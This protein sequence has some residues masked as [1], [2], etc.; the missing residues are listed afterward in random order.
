MGLVRFG[1]G[2]R[3]NDDNTAMYHKITKTTI[4]QSNDFSHSIGL[5]I[6][7][8]RRGRLHVV[9]VVPRRRST[10]QGGLFQYDGEH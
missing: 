6:Y 10:H 9:A 2:Y 5:E 7:L 1:I 8:R 3:H 4:A